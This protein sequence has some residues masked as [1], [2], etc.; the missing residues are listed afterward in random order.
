MG[1]EHKDYIQQ[2]FNQ[3]IYLFNEIYIN[4]VSSITVPPPDK[5]GNYLV[6]IA[7]MVDYINDAIPQVLSN[8]KVIDSA[9][10]KE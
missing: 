1:K 9:Q 2:Q 5:D 8:P 7:E 10:N 3:K 6:Q 4:D